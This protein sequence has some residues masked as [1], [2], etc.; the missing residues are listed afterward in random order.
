MI[1]LYTTYETLTISPHV[2]LELKTLVAVKVAER[3][4]CNAMLQ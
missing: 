1:L 2:L 3:I 4:V